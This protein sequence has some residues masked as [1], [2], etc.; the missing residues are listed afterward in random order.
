MAILRDLPGLE[1]TIEVGGRALQEYDVPNTCKAGIETDILME[2]AEDSYTVT[3]DAKNIPLVI[4]Y[5][6]A[7]A[8][9]SSGFRFRKQLA[10]PPGC[11]HLAIEAQCDGP[12]ALT[13]R[14]EFEKRFLAR[15]ALARQYFDDFQY[16]VCRPCAIF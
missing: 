10:F 13:H 6:E 14:V 16:D 2:T 9:K 15:E 4:S 7:T 1:A 3:L 11:H 12:R 8:G 5:V